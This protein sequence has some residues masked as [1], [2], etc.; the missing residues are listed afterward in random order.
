M[1]R[2]LLR[3][4]RVAP[5]RHGPLCEQN[6][7]SDGRLCWG[8][9]IVDCPPPLPPPLPS[10][11]VR[12]V[13]SKIFLPCEV[14][15]VVAAGDSVVATAPSRLLH[16]SESAPSL[17]VGK[18]P[19]VP[20]GVSLSS[21]LSS[22]PIGYAHDTISVLQVVERAMG[23]AAG[24]AEIIV[25]NA[26]V[27]RIRRCADALLDC[28]LAP[29]PNGGD[30]VC[31]ADPIVR[32]VQCVDSN[33]TRAR[34]ACVRPERS[35]E[36]IAARVIGVTLALRYLSGVMAALARSCTGGM[37]DLLCIARGD[38]MAYATQARA[39]FI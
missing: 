36:E 24:G 3:A 26:V 27:R 15:A 1:K 32:V 38:I 30:N 13:E 10:P 18:T 22:I 16:L 19:R 8:D 6:D 34:L 28:A 39:G 17:P 23:E 21:S 25:L 9:E 14:A 5:W 29:V 11:H 31:L 12:L 7:L 4:E 37:S 35:P 20:A 33:V 2:R